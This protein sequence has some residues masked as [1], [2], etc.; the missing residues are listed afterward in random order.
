MYGNHV[1]CRQRLNFTEFFFTFD[2]LVNMDKLCKDLQ[3]SL[4][5]L[6]DEYK[7]EEIIA[8][9]LLDVKDKTDRLLLA[10]VVYKKKLTELMKPHVEKEKNKFHWAT[11]W[12]A[13]WFEF[14]SK[15]K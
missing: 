1:D 3:I 11:T 9:S 12:V 10:D 6:K 13:K 15:Y 2:G 5:N 8:K 4:L 14:I 7:R